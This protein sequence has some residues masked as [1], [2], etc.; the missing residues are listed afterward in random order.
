MELK[1][2]MTDRIC[3]LA[4]TC[5]LFNPTPDPTE[6]ITQRLTAVESGLREVKKLATQIPDTTTQNRCRSLEARVTLLVEKI[7]ALE[8]AQKDKPEPDDSISAG[9]FVKAWDREQ[10]PEG[11]WLTGEAEGRLRALR[12]RVREE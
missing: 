5:E 11:W 1:P 12:D 6:H 9:E 4:G 2:T 8:A 7:H 10:S 3:K